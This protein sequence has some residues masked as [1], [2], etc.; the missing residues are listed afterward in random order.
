MII[1]YIKNKTKLINQMDKDKILSYFD[2][3]LIELLRIRGKDAK[4]FNPKIIAIEKEKIKFGMWKHY[5]LL[6]MNIE[7]FFDSN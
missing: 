6:V 3:K 7:S 4:V 2:I 1:G 5:G